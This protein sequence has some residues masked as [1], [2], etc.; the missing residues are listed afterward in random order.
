MKSK[1]VK[2][3]III[4]GLYEDFRGKLNFINDFD[5]SP[6]KRFYQ[7]THDAV[8]FVRAW[9]GHQL[10]QKWFYCIK[11]SFDVK[12]IKVNNWEKPSKNLQSN[13]FELSSTRPEILHIPS[14]Y[15]SG[16]RAV[17][18]ESSMIIYSDKNLKDS[19]ADDFRFERDYWNLW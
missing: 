7:V 6:V 19:E 17:E 18:L 13:N 3:N 9:Q 2:P 11:G 1:I 16:F 4:G 14:G 10:E 5:L 8:D 12:L 15:V